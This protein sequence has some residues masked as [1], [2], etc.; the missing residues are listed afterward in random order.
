MKRWLFLLRLE[1]GLIFWQIFTRAGHLIC[2]SLI[3]FE[4]EHE[5]LADL[6]KFHPVDHF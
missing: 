1:N 5:A 6:R 4:S 2:R 3:V